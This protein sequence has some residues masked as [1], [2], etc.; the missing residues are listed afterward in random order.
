MMRNQND[1][2]RFCTNKCTKKGSLCM[3]CFTV[4][5]LLIH[6]IFA[7][8]TKIAATKDAKILENNDPEI[9]TRPF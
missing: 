4:N 2:L 5:S 7:Q 1:S 9:K 3:V 8:L 6:A